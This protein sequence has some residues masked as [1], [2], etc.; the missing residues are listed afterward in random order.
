MK[1]IREQLLS[2]GTK[3]EMHKF[4]VELTQIGMNFVNTCC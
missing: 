4:R 1:K 3:I 2:A